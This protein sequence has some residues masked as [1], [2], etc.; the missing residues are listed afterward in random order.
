MKKIILI[1]LIILVFITVENVRAQNFSFSDFS[2]DYTYCVDTTRNT[3]IVDTITFKFT[4]NY[5]NK[6]DVVE[7]INFLFLDV[8]YI[9]TIIIQIRCQVDIIL[10]EKNEFVILGFGEEDAWDWSFNKNNNQFTLKKNV[11]DLK[12]PSIQLAKFSAEY[13]PHHLS[14]KHEPIRFGRIDIDKVM[15]FYRSVKKTIYYK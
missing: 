9:D 2:Y 15:P 14:H 5:K 10:N 3:L 12:V 13:F 6:Q 7:G 4:L 8:A 1:I 11:A